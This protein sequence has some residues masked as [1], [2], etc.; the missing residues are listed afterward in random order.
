MSMHN[1]NYL[2]SIFFAV[3]MGGFC[4]CAPAAALTN[5]FLNEIG[6]RENVSA[7]GGE[8]CFI[9]VVLDPK[10]KSEAFPEDWLL[11]IA[12]D[13]SGKILA[14][15]AI[16]SSYQQFRVDA[17][18]LDGDGDCEFIFTTGEGRGTSVRKEFLSIERLRGG[19]LRPVLSLPFSD[20]YSSGKRWWYSAEFRDSDGN[21]TVDVV[22]MLNADDASGFEYA[23][24]ERAKVLRWLR[25][26]KKEDPISSEID[27]SVSRPKNPILR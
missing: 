6:H 9:K 21:G 16:H 17:V 2:G 10:H 8:N 27:L 19:K 22:L 25:G 20:Y 13:A 3:C 7:N 14:R 23:P 1:L 12:T 4:T 5:R 24:V 26:P 11:F 18:D 15:K